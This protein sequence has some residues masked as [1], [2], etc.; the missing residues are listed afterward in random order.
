[1]KINIKEDLNIKT[2]SKLQFQS[3]QTS[4]SQ[5]SGNDSDKLRI[6]YRSSARRNLNGLDFK[7]EFDFM[8]KSNRNGEETKDNE[9][10]SAVAKLINMRQF[11]NEVGAKPNEDTKSARKK[12]LGNVRQK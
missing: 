4:D 2:V 1:M 7:N 5:D 11:F 12:S 8:T 9:D 3:S 10:N 6:N